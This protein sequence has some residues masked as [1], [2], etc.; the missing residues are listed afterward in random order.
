MK[1]R[2]ATK[3]SNLTLVRTCRL[4]RPAAQR[5]RWAIGEEP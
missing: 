1:E 2:G 4:R 3:R 5:Y